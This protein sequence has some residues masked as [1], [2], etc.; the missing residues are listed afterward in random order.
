MI[1]STIATDQNGLRQVDALPV[2]GLDSEVKEVDIRR[3]VVCL[4]AIEAKGLVR[5]LV[6]PE[7]RREGQVQS[8][9]EGFELLRPQPLV[10]VASSRQAQYRNEVEGVPLPE[11]EG[12]L[13]VQLLR[14][15]LED[16]HVFRG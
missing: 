13:G 3:L 7:L 8:F 12:E 14:R 6:T 11:G 2:L 10:V 4:R 15:S 5:L 16:L 1:E 9:L